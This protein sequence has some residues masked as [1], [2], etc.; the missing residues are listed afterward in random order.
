[1]YVPY[2][3]A[4]LSQITPIDFRIIPNIGNE[5]PLS[6][7]NGSVTSSIYF[8][9]PLWFRVINQQYNDL[10]GNYYYSIPNCTFGK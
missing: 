1:M 7:I 8:Q 2:V 10:G 3:N 6:T 5:L 4:S 9:I